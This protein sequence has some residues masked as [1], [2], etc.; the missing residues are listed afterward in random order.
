MSACSFGRTE[1]VIWLRPRCG[2]IGVEA[3]AALIAELGPQMVLFGAARAMIRQFAGRHRDEQSIVSVDQLH[4]AHDESV[5][6]GE[7]AKRL[8][9]ARGAPGQRLMRISVRCMVILLRWKMWGRNGEEMS[10]SC[11]GT[12]I[13]SVLATENRKWIGQRWLVFGS[14]HATRAGRLCHGVDRRQARVRVARAA[15]EQP[16]A[17]RVASSPLPLQL[18]DRRG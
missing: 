7:R 2:A 13:L 17:A 12:G 18:A 8:Q 3:M 15:P 1:E 10:K 9:T 16:V 4:V 14:M 11:C 5:V 6:E